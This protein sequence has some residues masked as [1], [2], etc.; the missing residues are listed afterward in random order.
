[1]SFENLL[2]DA[3]Q[4]LKRNIR[5]RREQIII[6]PDE[7]QTLSQKY[8]I[9]LSRDA[10]NGIKCDQEDKEIV[11][12]ILRWYYNLWIEVNDNT[13]KI[14]SVFPKKFELV[15]DVDKSNHPFTPKVF[16][17]GTIMYFGSS[18]GMCNW[19]KGV[20]LWDDPNEEYEYGLKP[21]VQVNY[22][23]LRVL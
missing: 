16:K 9:D 11:I 8:F 12:F 5:S 13:I 15:D 2:K 1:M 21:T 18:S 23:F 10:V 14:H 4:G 19:L 17:K 20:P 3:K 6:T 7:F 22:E